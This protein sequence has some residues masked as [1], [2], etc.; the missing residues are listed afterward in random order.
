MTTDKNYMPISVGTG[1][2][3]GAAYGFRNPS[4]KVCKKFGKKQTFPID[5]S[6]N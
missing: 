5:Q 4:E 1:A 2:V 6:E 3:I